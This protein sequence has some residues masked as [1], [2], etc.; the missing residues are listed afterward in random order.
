M[1]PSKKS[2]VIAVVD[3]EKCFP[4]R[5]GEPCV[6]YDPINRSGGEGFHIGPDGKAHIDENIVTEAHKICAKKCPFNAIQ[7]INL[8][9]EP[10]NPLHNYGQ[11][12]FRCYNIAIPEKGKVVGLLGPN[13]I[14]KTT[15]LKI[16]STQIKPNLGNY[17]N[18]PEWEEILKVFKGNEIKEFLK[19]L[20]S[21]KIK[22]IYKP[23]QVDL[24]PK[25]V[26]TEKTVNDV[27]K[28]ERK[29]K[30]DIIEKL[31]L[32]TIL[33]RKLAELSGGELQ[34][35]AIAAAICKE[36]D[37][38]YFDEPS[39]F[40]DVYHRVQMAKVI[41]ELADLH[42]KSVVVVEHDLAT[43]DFLTDTI[44][45]VYGSPGAYGVISNSY[46]SR[47]G[48]NI[49]L[50]GL[51]KE[52]NVRF[53]ETT[54]VFRDTGQIFKGSAKA[55]EYP[56]IEHSFGSGKNGFQLKV[57][58]GF[59]Y[60]G[61]VLGVV[62]R[63][64]LGKTTFAKI[65]AGELKPKHGELHTTAKISYKPQYL[66]GDYE[67][68]VEELLASNVKAYN[69]TE[70]KHE[71]LHPLEIEQLLMKKV[72]ILSGGELQRVAISLCLGKEADFYLLDEPSA[73]LDVDQ[74]MKL[75][76]MLR[77]FVQ[78]NKKACL[79]I[80]HDLMLVNYVSDRILM[81]AGEAGKSGYAKT[82]ADLKS[83]LNSFLKDLDITLRMDPDTGRPRTNKPMSQKDQEQR[84]SGNYYER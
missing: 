31:E 8:P 46:A 74:R 3:K 42:K 58:S 26:G 45:I 40:L 34:R 24:L 51:I 28:D 47:R 23:Q 25:A 19:E 53:R 29:V 64:A 27:I 71:V 52:E 9:K 7:I 67:G 82:P 77:K 15:I 32:T 81:F 1:D 49:F 35:V 20:S 16:L 44:Y 50:D 61:E 63:N 68:T 84:S 80:D 17:K 83:G 39:S 43:L 75:S 57:D 38:Y 70:F 12:Q 14:G 73:Y 37:I 36:A 55:I 13:G 22:T 5:S 76:K 65:L 10:G 4:H 60:R 72:S 79:V 18:A 54:L 33:K 59:I 62:G 30:K 78:N 69:S 56:E 48:I 66:K 6:K 11:N 41:R 2:F 21:N